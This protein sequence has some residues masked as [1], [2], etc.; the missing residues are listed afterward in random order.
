[1]RIL[2]LVTFV[3]A[4]LRPN[5]PDTKGEHWVVCGF[6]KVVPSNERPAPNS[7]VN[8]GGVLFVC[9]GEPKLA[10]SSGQRVANY[11]FLPVAHE[12]SL[13]AQG[14]SGAWR[15]VWPLAL[16]DR[17]KI[18]EICRQLVDEMGYAMVVQDLHGNRLT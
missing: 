14:A 8:A 6:K 13:A 4:V 10:Y 2:H 16:E 15:R 7:Y 11:N 1:M 17:P 3:F 12:P 18:G 5:G 9:A